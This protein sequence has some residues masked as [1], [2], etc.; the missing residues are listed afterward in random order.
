MRNNNAKIIALFGGSFDPPHIGHESIVK[1]ILKLKMVDKVV[2][3]PTYLNPFKSK[4]YAPSSL[5][6]KWL[7]DIFMLY[8]NV[9][10]DSYEINLKRKVPT[11]ESVHHL[12]KKYQKI[13]LIIGADNLKSL[14][15]WNH[16]DELKNL[17]TFIVATRDDIKIP[18]NFIKLKVEENISSTSLRRY[19]DK[20]KLSHICSDEITKFYKEKNEK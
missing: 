8:E 15:Q 18:T 17:V 3:M 19:I 5:R 6:L 13:Y 16:Y 10:V 11:I 12:L 1:E 4:F 7:Q 20:S 2:I 9:E 14:S